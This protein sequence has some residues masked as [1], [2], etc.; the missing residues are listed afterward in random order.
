M[1]FESYA[2]NDPVSS[3]TDQGSLGLDFSEA[4]GSQQPTARVPCEAGKL[5]EQPCA[6]GDGGDV[7]ESATIAASA[8]PG[9]LCALVMQDAADA[10]G[11]FY[12]VS[13][14]RASAE[15]EIYGINGVVTGRAGANLFNAAET[16]TSGSYHV[17]CA[18]FNGA[19][20]ELWLDGSSI[21]TGDAG[22]EGFEGLHVF[23]RFTEANGISGR[24]A[25]VIYYDT[26]TTA[27][28][29]VADIMSVLECEYGGG[30]PQ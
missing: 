15:H 22:T 4:T 20:S 29:M 10:S 6:S 19:S 24:I 11:T 12:Y 3:L 2:N 16:F 17:V 18:H 7:L 28:T 9:L 5:G 23:S 8:Q 26:V 30:F 27:S 14:A 13:G 21:A 25:E 1:R